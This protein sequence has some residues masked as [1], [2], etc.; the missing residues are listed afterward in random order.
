MVAIFGCKVDGKIL[1]PGDSIYIHT[2]IQEQ[3]D[4]FVVPIF[5][6]EVNRHVTSPSGVDVSTSIQEKLDH[7]I[8]SILRCEMKG[9][10]IWLSESIGIGTSNQKEIDHLI[11]AIL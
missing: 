1:S 9:S 8:M 4:H 3:L 6:C 5:R 11:M 10:A 7:L 2:S